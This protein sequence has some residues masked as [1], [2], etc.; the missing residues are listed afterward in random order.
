M[1]VARQKLGM[2]AGGMG[3]PSAGE[4]FR[5]VGNAPSR[6]RQAAFRTRLLACTRRSRFAQTTGALA[7]PEQPRRGTYAPHCH[8]PRGVVERR[9]L[10]D[11]ALHLATRF[12]SDEPPPE[13]ELSGA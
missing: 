10:T 1:D 9:S 11:R 5:L 13:P 6:Q 12:S 7:R 8:G 4:L 2:G 3:S